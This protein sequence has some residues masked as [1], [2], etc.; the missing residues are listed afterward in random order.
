M[1]KNKNEKGSPS[2][3]LIAN[4]MAMWF[5]ESPLCGHVWMSAAALFPA[6]PLEVRGVVFAF[7]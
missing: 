4:V 3:A 7:V 1:E 6:G 5:L 2:V